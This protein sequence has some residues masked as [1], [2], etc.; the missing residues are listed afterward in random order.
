MH[1]AF[2]RLAG[3]ESG[4]VHSWAYF[5]GILHRFALVHLQPLLPS[6][7]W[8]FLWRGE[9]GPSEGSHQ[10]LCYGMWVGAAAK[11]GQLH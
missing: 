8:E 6:R 9:R 7:I 10:A 3:P 11:P 5:F 2:G 1:E 4:S